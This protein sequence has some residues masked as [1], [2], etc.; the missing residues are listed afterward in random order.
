MTTDW[1]KLHFFQI[2]AA[3]S[4]LSGKLYTIK[5][6]NFILLARARFLVLCIQGEKQ[7]LKCEVLGLDHTE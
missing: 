3:Q 4:P 7:I 5:L 6:N 2:S 1:L